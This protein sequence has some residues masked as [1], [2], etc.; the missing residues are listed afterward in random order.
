MV[1]LKNVVLQ[2]LLEKQIAALDACL[3]IHATLL[4]DRCIRDSVVVQQALCFDLTTTVYKIANCGHLLGFHYFETI[5][6][7][8]AIDMFRRTINLMH[9]QAWSQG[10]RA[11]DIPLLKAL[12]PVDPDIQS[13]I[14]TFIANHNAPAVA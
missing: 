3:R 4:E 1:P 2:Q 6:C 8:T 13:L 5:T 12:H 9:D 7:P 11:E 10:I 14:E